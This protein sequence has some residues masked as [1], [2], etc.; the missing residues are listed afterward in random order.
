VG[1]RVFDVAE[2]DHLKQRNLWPGANTIGDDISL[3]TGITHDNRHLTSTGHWPYPNT[4]MQ[5]LRVCQGK[6][7]LAYYEY[8]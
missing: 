1:G 5:D 2:E 7:T 3:N 4:L 6:Y 8:S